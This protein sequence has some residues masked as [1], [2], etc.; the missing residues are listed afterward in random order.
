MRRDA[1]H[2]S[3]ARLCVCAADLC[4]AR[5]TDLRALE[6]RLDSLVVRMRHPISGL[7]QRTLKKGDTTSLYFAGKDLVAWLRA[8]EHGLDSDGAET[9]CQLLLN[10]RAIRPLGGFKSTIK[11]SFS[12]DANYEFQVSACPSRVHVD[13]ANRRG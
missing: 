2:G 5:K 8:A 9:L 13:S 4:A 1:R 11:D 12:V 10:F 6:Q 7:A 3:S